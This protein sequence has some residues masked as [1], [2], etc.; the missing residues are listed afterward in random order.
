MLTDKELKLKFDEL[1]NLSTE[2]EWVEFKPKSGIDLHNLGRYFSALSNEARLHNKECGWIV[3]G[4]DDKTHQIVGTNYKDTP[5]SL[6]KLKL[7]ITQDTTNGIGFL[8]VYEVFESNK[9]VLM[10]AVPSAPYGMP[11]AWKNKFYGRDGSSLGD[12][13]QDEIDRIRDLK[14][15]DWSSQIC[16][17]ARVEHLDKGAIQLAR[18]NFIDKA[19]HE[20]SGELAKMI[21]QCTDE[22]FLKKTCIITPNGKVTR[23]ALLLLGMPESAYFLNPAD[24]QLTWVLYDDSGNK[25]DYEHFGPPYL[26]SVERIFQKI[27]NLKHRYLPPNTLFPTEIQQYD[28]WVLREALNNAIVHQN[29]EMNGRI[30][31]KEYSDRIVFTNV[32]NFFSGDV[33]SFIL[34]PNHVPNSYRNP[35]LCTA[36]HTL[37]MID[38][39]GSGIARM[40]EVQ[41]RRF[42]PLPEWDIQ[43][44][45]VSITVYGKILDKKFTNILIEKTD[46]DLKIVLALDRV[47]KRKPLSIEQI[48]LLK[49]KKLI[50]GRKPNFFI[51]EKIAQVSDSK[52]QYTKQK[53]F[54]D[55]YYEDLILSFLKQ[56]M[57]ATPEELR[58]LLLNKLSDRLNEQQRRHK[59]RNV[60]QKMAKNG[61]IK[62]LGK[63]GKGAVWVLIRPNDLD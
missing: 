57:K 31:V 29:Y 28:D 1:Q 61:F 9:R 11:I 10:F 38:K 63:H 44:D 16:G 21:S 7:E 23:S 2:T 22:T 53:A 45:R 13:K 39:L 51:S 25:R 14:Q 27:R 18:K 60:T 4:V 46:L 43:P 56:H 52:V 3:F 42:F 33:E 59:V 62:N 50:E 12:L 41:R 6:D 30:V 48:K 58:D 20:E 49:S 5:E 47:Q 17:D 8:A 32:G 35:W 40:S 36:M 15:K 19:R 34:D 37:K 24:P 55:K 26:V 54:D